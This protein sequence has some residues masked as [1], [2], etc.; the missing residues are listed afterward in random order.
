MSANIVLLSG[1]KLSRK[2]LIL[3]VIALVLAA[4]PFYQFYSVAQRGVESAARELSGFEPTRTLL[5]VVN[6]TQEHRGLAAGAFGGD[7]K[8]AAQLPNKRGDVDKALAELDRN[9]QGIAE[10]GIQSVWGEVR[11]E[12]NTVGA[13]VADR[14]F[15]AAES[16]AAHTH[17]IEDYLSLLD[18]MLDHFGLSLDPKPESAFLVGAAYVTIPQMNE[19]LGQL[20]GLGTGYLAKASEQRRTGMF[21]GDVMSLHD[22][23][24]LASLNGQAQ[25]NLEKTSL[26]LKK[27]MNAMPEL[28]R[29]LEGPLSRVEDMTKRLLV[30]ID[31]EV[32]DSQTWTLDRKSVV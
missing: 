16:F 13:S 23:S 18:L 12:W 5:R 25:F 21:A 19:A 26:L 24:T 32:A 17:L 1:L 15:S 9:M 6:L 28:K 2:F 30:M 14:A 27:A 4:V 29:S 22:R 7:A 8:L 10:K 31:D 20:R 11:Q 3:G